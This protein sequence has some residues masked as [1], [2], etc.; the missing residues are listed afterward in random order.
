MLRIAKGNRHSLE[1]F[2]P[3]Q[4]DGKQIAF[5]ETAEHVGIIRSSDGNIPHI[6]NRISSH[7]K[8][9]GAKLSSGTAQKSRANPM[10]GLRLEKIYGTPVLLS[11]LSSLVLSKSEIASI[12]IHQKE[13]YQNLQ[14]F[15]HFLSGTLPTEA[16]IHLRMLSLFGMVAR[17]PN[18]PLNIHARN[19]LTTRKSSSKSWFQQLRDICL[20]YWIPHPLTFLDNPPDKERFKKLIKSRIIVIFQTTIFKPH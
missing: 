12:E 18:D 15:V 2:N 6:M 4:I 16:V 3:I 20:M 10:V 11:G 19:V 1:T 7:R 13:T 5:S 9:L 8:A 14:C 17:L